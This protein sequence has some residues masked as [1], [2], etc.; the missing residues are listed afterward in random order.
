[1]EFLG[2]SFVTNALIIG[3]FTAI[4]TAILGNFVIVARQAV[5]SDMLSHAAITGVGLGVFWNFSP[6][7]GAFITSMLATLFLWYFSQKK[8]QAP[9]AISVVLL[10]GS[11]GL[12]LLLIHLD[13]HNTLSLES[14]LFGSILT[15]SANEFYLF[16]ILNLA[17]IIILV[18]FWKKFLTLVFDKDFLY[19]QH[20]YHK[21]FEVLL[22]CLIAM[23]VAI[24]LKVIGGLLIGAMLIIPALTVQRYCQSFK[25]S[26]ISSILLNIIAIN[27]GL[28][29]SFYI[30]IPSSSGIVLTHILFFILAKIDQFIR[31]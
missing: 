12:A 20:P 6:I 18:V 14:Y 22:M 17:I 9:E 4:A 27:I 29:S 30:D 5:M 2:Y 26:V 24:G 7:W 13:S 10:N 25:N 23:I 28:I 3:I 19:S 16:I 8:H 31:S 15:I 1:M 11:L 21:I